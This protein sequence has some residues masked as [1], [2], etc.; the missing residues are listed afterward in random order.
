[1]N[2]FVCTFRERLID[3]RWQEWNT[4]VQE[5]DRFSMYRLFNPF[6]SIPV[7]LS[8]SMN[9]QMRYVMTRFRLGV[10]DLLVHTLRYRINVDSDL[11]CP[12]CKEAKESEIHFVFCCPALNDLRT[13]LIPRKY[14]IRPSSFRLTLLMTFTQEEIIKRVALFLCRAFK[15]RSTVCT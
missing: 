15:V 6:H 12:L 10:S 7:H 11:T 8:M 2:Q 3:C 13:E 5:S 1:M 9:S 4:H 14:Y